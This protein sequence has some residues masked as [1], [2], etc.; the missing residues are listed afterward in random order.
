MKSKRLLAIVI[1]TIVTLGT[2]STAFASPVEEKLKLMQAAGEKGILVTDSVQEQKAKI[3]KDKAKEIGIA[4]LKE[5][6]E[7]ELD[8]SK[9]QSRIEFRPSYYNIKDDYVWDMNWNSNDALASINVNVSINANTGKVIALGKHEYSKFEQQ[10][11]IPNITQDKAKE[12][13]EAFMQKINPEKIAY[14]KLLNEDRNYYGYGGYHPVNYNFNYQRQVNGVQLEGDFIRV[15]VDGVTGKVVSFE[16]RWSENPNITSLEGVIGKDKAEEIFRKKTEMELMYINYRSKYDY[17][18]QSNTV[19]LVY[20][21]GESAN[22]GIDAKTGSVLD[23]N[24]LDNQQIETKDLTAE[25]RVEWLKKAAEVKA[26]TVEIDNARAQQ[27]IIEKLKDIFGQ[28]YKVDY[29]SYEENKDNYETNGRKAW[30]ANFYREVDGKRTEDG[31]SVTIDALTEEIIALY[32]YDN[33]YRYDEEF[34]PKLT[35]NQAYDAAIEAAAKFYPD[36]IKNIKTEMK[37]IVYKQIVNDKQIPEREYYFSFPRL[38]NGITYGNDNIN[39]TFDAKTGT[40]RQVSSR[41]SDSIDFP[42]PNGAMKAEEA[43][44]IVFEK[45][46]PELVYALMPSSQGD[47]KFSG[48]YKLIYRLKPVGTTFIAGF[49]DAFNGKMLNYDGQEISEKSSEFEAKIKGHKAEKELSILAFQGIIDTAN[50]E[51][52]KEVT[53]LDFIKMLVD[54]KGYRPY[55]VRES[56]ALKYSNVTADN[57][58]YRYL[59]MG[60]Y[61]GILENKEGE[62]DF[63][64]KVTREEM[65]TALVKLLGYENLAKAKDIFVLDVADRS[66]IGDDSLGYMAIA[67]ALG[68]LEIDNLKI[69]AKETA[70]MVEMAAG[71]YKVLGNLRNGSY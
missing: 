65:A 52:N 71:I 15:E 38:T 62:F 3:T 61:Y 11:S 67:K 30:R 55:L 26:G 17:E 44:D 56:A 33:D 57:E 69:R 45:L 18:S 32:K 16:S 1:A 29:L 43:E 42:S 20:N 12:V 51:L 48:E 28:E 59:Q 31:G 49:I 21:M 8:E 70:T 34:T 24:Y 9:F 23:Y 19:K 5:Y 40:L 25:Q 2:T 54:A 14:V 36:K 46:K 41:W 35:W 64:K 47:S 27:V 6:L 58:N 39:I 10:P 63:N 37:H 50:F 60:V 68:I 4:K 66:E 53:M 7:Y 22:I 13:V